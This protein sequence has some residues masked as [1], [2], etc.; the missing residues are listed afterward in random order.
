MLPIGISSSTG[1]AGLEF[2]GVSGFESISI[3][4]IIILVRKK[5]TRDPAAKQTMA[6]TER[7]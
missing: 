7:A 2:I 6:H 1:V 5:N 3:F 4:G